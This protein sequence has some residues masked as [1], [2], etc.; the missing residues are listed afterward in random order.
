MHSQRFQK[1]Y[2]PIFLS[3]YKPHMRLFL[4]LIHI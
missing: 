2:V 3:Y 1:G 4:S